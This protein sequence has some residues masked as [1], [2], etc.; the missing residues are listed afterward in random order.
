MKLGVSLIV[1]DAG[2]AALGLFRGIAGFRISSAKWLIRD[3]R[4][5][6]VLTTG[7]W[8]LDNASVA[9]FFCHKL[10]VIGGG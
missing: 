3:C 4:V 9:S 7:S 5:C 1:T 8:D 2:S 10:I 6:R